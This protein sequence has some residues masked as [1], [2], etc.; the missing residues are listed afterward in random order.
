MTR[1]YCA[2]CGRVTHR[3]ECAEA[4]SD[5]RQFFARGHADFSP[6]WM[7]TPYKRGVPPQIKRRERATLRRNYQVWYND[8]V[9][10]HGA[11]CAN[12]G[13]ADDT[14]L[15]IDHVL[16]IARGGL[17]AYVNLQLLCA[18]CNRIKG[19]LCIACRP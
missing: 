15:V 16:S 19:K 12:C 5:I 7:D 1:R 6:L 18:E 10:A 17:S 3:C 13:I 4:A 9:A 14:Q 11:V 2:Y 8:L